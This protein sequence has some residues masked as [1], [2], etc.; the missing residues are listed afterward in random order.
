MEQATN[1]FTKGLQCDTNPMVQD[2]NTL[3]DCL[4]GTLITMNG[5]EVVL[6][7][8][9]GNRR[10]DNAFLPE[11]YEPVGIK[12]YGGIIYIAA[13]NPITNK[14]QI[15]SFPSPQLRYGNI[16]NIS[17]NED[18]DTFTDF[19]LDNDFPG[20]DFQKNYV[21]LTPFL[22]TINGN[23]KK[24]V[25]LHAG[26]KFTIY[27]GN[28]NSENITNYNNILNGKLN[29]P[30]NKKYTLSVGILNSQNEFVDFTKHLLR[31]EL[32]TQTN[33]YQIITFPE[34]TPDYIKF[35]SGYFIPNEYT[36]PQDFYYTIQDL[37]FIKNRLK[38]AAKTYA[39]KLV[40]PLYIKR[41][42]NV[43][44]NLTY[45]VYGNIIKVKTENL[46]HTNTEV[47]IETIY[48]YN[49]PDNYPN[50]TESYVS[51]ED[52]NDKYYS[53]YRLTKSSSNSFDLGS[54]IKYNY[55]NSD[56]WTDITND[57]TLLEDVTYNEETNLYKAIKYTKITLS[58][59]SS[60][61]MDLMIIPLTGQKNNQN[62]DLGIRN[63]SYRDTIDISKLSSNEIE[64]TNFRFY[65]NLDKNTTD[66]IVGFKAYPKYRT[67][68]KDLKISIY[69]YNYTG[70]AAPLEVFRWGDSGYNGIKTFTWK[71]N[72]SQKSHFYPVI[73]TYTID[74][75]N[76][77][78]V[79]EVT[80]N[81]T[82]T[83]VRWIMTT[84]L[85]NDCYYSS[86]QNF[87]KDYG[88]YRNGSFNQII[89]NKLNIKLSTN[90]T[91]K[92]DVE[93]EYIYKSGDQSI[94]K[95]GKI[96]GQ[97][98]T[99]SDYTTSS[100]NNQTFESK[101]TKI[102]NEN[103]DV[104]GQFQFDRDLYPYELV[105][106]DED[107][108]IDGNENPTT[109]II[110][111]TANITKNGIFAKF[112]SN[113]LFNDMT[114]P[115]QYQANLYTYTTRPEFEIKRNNLGF[116]INY[117]TNFIGEEVYLQEG[118]QPT[119][120]IIEKLFTSFYKYIHDNTLKPYAAISVF[121]NYEDNDHCIY[122]SHQ[123]GNTSKIGNLDEIDNFK[124]PY[125]LVTF[126]NHS[127]GRIKGDDDKHNY[128][129]SFTQ[130][131]EYINNAIDSYF[132]NKL[133]FVGTNNNWIINY[134]YFYSEFKQNITGVNQDYVPC[135]PIMFWMKTQDGWALLPLCKW[136]NNHSAQAGEGKL[137]TTGHFNMVR[138]FLGQALKDYENGNYPNDLEKQYF[139]DDKIE[140]YIRMRMKNFYFVGGQNVPKKVY[141]I[142]P[143]KDANI[144]RNVGTI[145]IDL[146]L[147]IT[148]NDFTEN[149]SINYILEKYNTK[150]NTNRSNFF[151]NT[152]SIN[153]ISVF[154]KDIVFKETEEFSDLL[155]S[156]NEQLKTNIIKTA[157][158][159]YD[160][161]DNYNLSSS[162]CTLSDPYRYESSDYKQSLHFSDENGNPFNSDLLYISNDNINNKKY[163]Y[164]PNLP[165]QYD[166][167]I[168]LVKQ[169]YKESGLELMYC[170]VKNQNLGDTQ[171]STQLD[172][173][174]V[175]TIP[176][177]LL[178]PI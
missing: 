76:L 114:F 95:S 22:E 15:G 125:P 145:N 79:G 99:I 86:S 120:I 127:G 48:E 58:D 52:G 85:L 42:L 6:Q 45:N 126:A 27:K 24:K 113:Y 70:N 5:N 94:Y 41:E 121:S 25:I 116:S 134:G 16:E 115:R 56:T 18:E 160:M 176:E 164:I 171:D 110:T 55:E 156:F 29:S 78:L 104:S 132:G 162:Q 149:N 21:S 40:G 141:C 67:S 11:G 143:S 106:S 139:D 140:A 4:N 69:D 84:K 74:N 39:Y 150:Y 3:T 57:E 154:S 128:A 7:N 1:Q 138:G 65:T 119:D 71:W 88:E 166:G 80:A 38:L 28:L 34:E 92:S 137:G 60:G 177:V 19:F 12:E 102:Y 35:N 152:N 111:K 54:I 47:Y 173:G 101:V 63:L 142:N 117:N 147:S 129:F 93:K 90:I 66:I 131:K 109:H 148:L 153:N 77:S 130:E 124:T 9:M 20:I 36:P 169:E 100:A 161:T 107:I 43:I 122:F 136:E 135:R 10:V 23:N 75:S 59:I 170:T 14:S 32:N 51:I 44:N 49:C 8:D 105:I 87:V 168:P 159:E 165:V 178:K 81:E 46:E 151:K 158:E 103:I 72:D 163:K 2:N 146:S 26:D 144:R 31:W 62:K 53:F 33:K 89:E 96:T 68:F 172:M 167:L 13:Y 64:L 123:G 112:N 37:D 91:N 155:E 157:L 73:I 174:N 98:G 50:G 82:V 17:A 30:K 118:L 108:I 175:P 97:S 61:L 83:I 133:C